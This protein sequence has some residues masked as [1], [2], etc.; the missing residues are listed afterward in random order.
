M[1]LEEISK[2]K[3]ADKD[4]R[5]LPVSFYPHRKERNIP[6]KRLKNAGRRDFGAEKKK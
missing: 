6:K 5:T 3:T 4:I 1:F 2:R